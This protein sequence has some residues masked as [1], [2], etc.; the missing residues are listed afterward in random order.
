MF[1]CSEG[2][3]HRPQLLVAEHGFQ[4]IE[5]G[6][7]TQHE[8]AIEFLLLLDLVGIDC[9]VLIADRRSAMST[10]QSI[11]TRS[12][13]KKFDG[14]FVLRTN[15]DLNPLEA[16]LCYKQLWT[17]EQT[18]RTANAC[19]TRPIFHKLRR[20]HPRPR[21]CSSRWCSRRRWTI[22]SPRS[23][24]WVMAADHGRSSTELETE[25][26]HDT[27]A[28]WVHSA[29]RP[30]ASLVIRAVGVASSNRSPSHRIRLTDPKM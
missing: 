24:R 29:P 7:G 20:D 30:A 13:E 21:S 22:V 4:R 6:V 12:A 3:L 26:E 27:S 10:S 14:I 16:M 11:P 8:D 28:S 25:I 15:T 19:S 18:F 9:E 17:V 1:G 5:V 2:L 23:G